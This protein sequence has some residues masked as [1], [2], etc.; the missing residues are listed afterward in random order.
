MTQ[1]FKTFSD[2][3]R[4]ATTVIF[5]AGLSG[6]LVLFALNKIKHLCD[7]EKK[8]W[9]KE[10]NKNVKNKL[11]EKIIRCEYCNYECLNSKTND[12]VMC[13]NNCDKVHELCYTRK[14]EKPIILTNLFDFYFV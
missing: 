2:L 4:S 8:R 9:G 1:I 12:M 10:K 7:D 13:L 5:G 14:N 3:D 11:F 6:R